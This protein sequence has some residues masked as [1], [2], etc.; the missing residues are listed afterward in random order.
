MKA[1]SQMEVMRETLVRRARTRED[2]PEPLA[3]AGLL[4]GDWIPVGPNNSGGRIRAIAIDPTNSNNI[5][6]GSVGGGI[7]RTTNAGTSWAPVNDFMANLAISSLVINPTN[8]SVMYAGT[9]GG[10]AL[11]GNE[12]EPISPDGLRG[13]GVFKSTDGGLTWNQLA[14]TNPADPMVCATAGPAC[15]WSYVNRLAISPNGATILAATGGGIWRSTDAGATWTQGAGIA[16]PLR[17]IDFD[18]TNNQKAIASNIGSALYSTDGG[19]TWT[20]S[21]FDQT[22]GA[23][24]K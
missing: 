8:P 9:G 11:A 17:D 22:I 10:F 7:W 19:A 5:W 1:R 2:Q 18:P 15:Q 16:A 20:F 23:E 14:K 6:V 4:P 13:L 21:S 3:M 12:G 24:W